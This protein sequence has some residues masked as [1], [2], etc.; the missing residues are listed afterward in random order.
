MKRIGPWVP[1]GGAVVAAASF[2]LPQVEVGSRSWSPFGLCAELADLLPISEFLYHVLWILSWLVVPLL[3]VAALTRR[4]PGR[5]GAGWVL[6][7]L[8]LLASFSLATFGSVLLTSVEADVRVAGPSTG[9]ALALF[10]LP[11]AASAVAVGRV[12]GGGDRRVTGRIV[13]ASL[14]LL[15]ALHALF[16]QGSGWEGLAAWDG[17]GAAVRPLPSAWAPFA[18]GLLVFLGEVLLLLR[19]PEPVPAPAGAAA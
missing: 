3:L 4:D 18:G 9:L 10:A 8:L 6:F 1:L 13:R 16:L 12:L 5:G 19:P 17:S 2:F 11:L 14:G 15:L 7:I